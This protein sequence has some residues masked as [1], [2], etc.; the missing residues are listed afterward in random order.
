MPIEVPTMPWPRLKWPVPRVRSATTSGTMTANTAAVTPSRSCTATSSTGLRH[1]WRTEGRGSA[2]RRSRSS[3][4]GRRPQIWRAAADPRRQRRH[5]EL[6]HDD[7][8][9]DQHRRP[10]AERMVTHAA[11]QRQHGGIGEMEQQAGSRRR[12][13]AADCASARPA[14]SAACRCRVVAATAPWARSGS[15]SAGEIM[16][17]ANSA[18]TEQ[19]HGDDEHRARGKQ[20]TAG[21]HRGR[22]QA[23]ADEAKRALRPSRS[24]IAAWPTR[25]RLIAA[26]AGPST[27][28]ASACRIE[29]DST[30]G[31]DRQ[32]RIGQGADADG[33][34]RDGGDEA[35]RAGG[36]DQCAARHLSDERNEAGGRQHEADIDLRPLS[37]R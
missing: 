29:A 6:R 30:I 3:S 36:I 19:Q 1:R 8:G 2:T 13:A 4:S 22:R 16:R 25:P 7:A 23:V 31:K 34:D 9:G 27:Q 15:I 10:V 20:I 14:W 26:M 21:A 5:H 37:A 28:L 32:R 18:G 33:R 35:F 12:S 17:S 11:H 24:P